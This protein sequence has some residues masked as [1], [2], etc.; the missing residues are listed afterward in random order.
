[1]SQLDSSIEDRY[2]RYQPFTV[3]LSRDL[4][5]E[6]FRQD[7]IA[8]TGK[9]DEPNLPMDQELMT[10][11]SDFMSNL[12]I[13]EQYGEIWYRRRIQH[14]FLKN[15]LT[16]KQLDKAHEHL[17]LLHR[18]PVMHRITQGD[19]MEHQFH[20]EGPAALRYLQRCWDVLLGVAEQSGAVSRSHPD[21]GHLYLGVPIDSLLEAVSA[22]C[23]LRWPVWH[24][25]A[26]GLASNIGVVHEQVLTGLYTAIKIHRKYP[27]FSSPIMEI[28]SGAGYVSYWLYV[29]GHRN[30]TVVDMPT[31]MVCHAY[32]LA[33]NLGAD[34]FSLPNEPFRPPIMGIRFM[35]ADQLNYDETE[36][37]V[38]IN[39]DGL[40]EYGPE[41][42]EFYLEFIARQGKSF[43]SV[44]EE[45]RYKNYGEEHLSVHHEIA[46]KWADRLVIEDRNID[47][48]R[49]GFVE[50]WY[51]I[52]KNSVD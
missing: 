26:W 9:W 17:N 24:G 21:F 20:N 5:P 16:F 34:T 36:Y 6:R 30:I 45:S 12:V 19:L 1:M 31:V 29:M 8:L 48:L 35:T 33:V 42:M 4:D 44:N 15:W 50:E 2:P 25:G 39:V 52:L 51:K 40:S 14:D 43:Y 47:W 49:P 38:I 32:Q 18:S 23:N 7:P 46:E 28:G 37:D 10:R 27:H 41:N 11:L 3:Q 13:D 22:K